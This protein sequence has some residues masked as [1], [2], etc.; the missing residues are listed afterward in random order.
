MEKSVKGETPL[1]EIR[2]FG[3]F[4]AIRAGEPL[5]PLRTRAEKWLLTLLA[6]RPGHAISR[7][8]LSATL[9]PDSEPALGLY[10]LRRC[11]TN[12]RKALGTRTDLLL[13]PTPHTLCLNPAYVRVDV[14]DFDAAIAEGSVASLEQAVALY[15]GT[16]L[17]DCTEEW[18]LT[19]RIERE[20]AHL[21]ALETLAAH[22]V[23]I[24][25]PT[26]AVRYLRLTIAA[27]PL[28]ETAYGA[29]MQALAVCGDHAA[30]TQV[31]RDLRLLLHQ[32]L[33]IAPAAE[34]E[35]LYRCLQQQAGKAVLP[36]PVPGSLPSRRLPV[37]LTNLVGRENDIEEIVGWLQKER[38]VT[39]L[40]SGGVGKTRLAIATAETLA[41][42]YTDGVWFV[43]LA[44]LSV[45]TL[46]AHTV[47]RT[48]GVKEET[49]RPI[50]ETLVNAMASRSLLLILDNCEHLLDACAEMADT[51][52]SQCP[53]LR[54]LATSREALGLMGEHRYYTPSLALPP[55]ASQDRPRELGGKDLAWLMEFGAIRLF[56]ERA[57][58]VQAAFRLTAQ[59]AASVLGVVQHLDGIPLAIELAAARV[60]SL[61]VAEIQPRLH[62]CMALLGGGHRAALP[63]QKTIRA[64]ID[65]S[66][67]LLT[68][69]EKALL[70]RLSVFAGGWSLEAVESI[71]ADSETEGPEARSFPLL[72][73]ENLFDVLTALTDK[74]LVAYE[75]L[76]GGAR[77]RMLETVRQ[78]ARDRLA[79]SGETLAWRRRHRDYF[80]ALAEEG[81]QKLRGPEQA[82]WLHT[83]E[84]EHD[85]LRQALR[86]CLEAGDA[87]ETGLRLGAALQ[88]FW[89][90]RG[91]LTEGRECLRAL[92]TRPEAAARTRARAAALNGAGRLASKQGDYASTRSLLEEGFDIFR[93]LGDRQGCAYSLVE[94]GAMAW[95]QGDYASAR[96]LLAEALEPLRE[97]RD[98]QGIATALGIQALVAW[99]QG[100]YASARALQEEE[101]GLRRAVGDFHGIANTLGNQGLVDCALGNYASARSLHEESIEMFRELGDRQGTAHSLCNLATVFWHQGDYPTF[102]ALQEESLEIRRQLGDRRGIAQ[103]LNNLA[104]AAANQGDY[105]S[106]R[107]L[108][109]ESLERRRQLGDRNGIA[110]CLGNMGH[111]ALKQDDH[112]SAHAL[113]EESLQIRQELGDRYGTAHCLNNLGVVAVHEGNYASARS[114]QS[115]SLN[116]FR[117]LGDRHGIGLL[118]EAFA[119]LNAAEEIPEK[120]ARLWGAAERLRDEI[121]SPILSSD[122][123]EHDQHVTQVRATLDE[124][125]FTQIW[126]EGRTMQTERAIEYALEDACHP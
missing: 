58:K 8:W 63:R 83:L 60:R 54:V 122:Q 35:A 6:L 46:V 47:A 12:L 3:F 97:A 32:E 39:L 45:P 51:L 81:N 41:V 59:N 117:E 105:A 36:L 84:I 126:A 43:E 76:P 26:A 93:E 104:T 69:K 49:G 62:D 103:C 55:A 99:N 75:A 80:L 120:A 108:F 21:A 22:A 34:T 124:E 31:Y 114:L 74:S 115:A 91:H 79:E 9:W 57:M 95:N 20:Q 25:Q 5:P 86:L 65:W 11:L 29:L 33:N 2:L 17:E 87:A 101:L 42:N 24:H 1:L 88:R 89:Q 96:S 77:Y 82:Q 107:T 100:D 40:G 94:L 48:L 68:E 106:A 44:S 56:V 109:E 92:L 123:D 28:R 53:T 64:L 38:L 118:L 78:Y 67:D 15:R 27:D 16:L 13:A 52:L 4:S 116:M 73:R 71:C 19:A 111:A 7:E 112:A 102:I 121:G 119:N 125:D 113:L 10:N 37:P 98:Q 61:S 70:L 72:S 50:L 90:T 18:A 30:V 66:Y 14:A 85:N 23:T 110:H